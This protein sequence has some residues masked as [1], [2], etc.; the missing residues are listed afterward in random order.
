MNREVDLVYRV[1]AVKKKKVGE[2]GE[3]EILARDCEDEHNGHYSGIKPRRIYLDGLGNCEIQ[4]S[5]HEE[6]SG[7]TKPLRASF[8]Y[9]WADM[10][11]TRKINSN[12]TV[13][14]SLRR[15][16]VHKD[17]YSGVNTHEALWNEM[18]RV[19]RGDKFVIKFM[20]EPM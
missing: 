15:I 17:I 20:Q 18:S 14:V 11:F 13:G 1:F 12:H 19:K 6:I 7:L 8:R 2:I 3:L 10:V 16:R 4:M 5:E 9:S